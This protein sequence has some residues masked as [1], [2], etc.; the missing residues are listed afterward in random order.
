MKDTTTS[1][2]SVSLS[3]FHRTSLWV[4]FGKGLNK[5]SLIFC[6][7]IGGGKL[8][9]LYGEGDGVAL[10]PA[11]RTLYLLMRPEIF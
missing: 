8:S 5:S 4:E 2:D 3:N 10:W 11:A 1:G 9:L 6:E 7:G